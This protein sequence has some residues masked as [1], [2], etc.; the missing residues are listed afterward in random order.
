MTVPQI[1][2]YIVNFSF[3]VLIFICNI[4]YWSKF[5]KK[6][7]MA[8]KETEALEK[9][10]YKPKRKKLKATLIDKKEAEIMT[11]YRTYSKRTEYYL[12]FITENNEE[13]NFTVD[14][15]TY[16]ALE[17][18]TQGTLLL[19]NDDYYDFKY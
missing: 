10:N 17:V 4:L 2:G 15:I 14:Q 3:L 18:N 11:S 6:R 5:F 12:K 1:I 16:E 7:K 9:G 19:C 8:Q 13:L